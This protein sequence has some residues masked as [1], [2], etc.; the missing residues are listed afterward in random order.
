MS[1]TR[2]TVPAAPMT[3]YRFPIRIKRV[4]LQ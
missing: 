2:E 1:P 4:G 3:N